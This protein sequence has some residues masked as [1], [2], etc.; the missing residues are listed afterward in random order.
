LLINFLCIHSN[1][2]CLHF[3][4][5]GC[6]SKCAAMRAGAAGLPPPPPP[7]LQDRNLKK[8]FVNIMISNVV[9]DLPFS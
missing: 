2:S 1:F 4:H 6:P 5:L 8:D 3:V 9:R 7:N